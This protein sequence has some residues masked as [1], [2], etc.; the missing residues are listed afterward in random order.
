M[1]LISAIE[2]DDIVLMLIAATLAQHHVLMASDG[3]TGLHMAREFHPDVILLDVGL[4][5]MNGQKVC[6]L[7]CQ[8]SGTKSTSIVLVT[9]WT[10]IVGDETVWREVGA[11]AAVAK[12]FSPAK[13]RA[14]INH[15]L[16]N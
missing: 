6:Q 14:I 3:A 7:M 11:T 1:A 10:E 15:L 8:D 9:A 5:V 16:A 13:L 2:D 12:P 4:P